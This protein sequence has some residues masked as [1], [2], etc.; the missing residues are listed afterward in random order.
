MKRI[1]TN[2][3]GFDQLVSGGIPEK[4]LVILTGYA[5]TGKTIFALQF[6]LAADEPGLFV[7]FE[8]DVDQIR[9][10]AR[11][12]GWN[13][14]E[15]E[16]NNKVRIVKYDPFRIGDIMEIIES[17]IKEIDAKRVVIDSISALGIHI[18]QRYEIRTVILQLNSILAKNDCTTLMIS[19][20]PDIRKGITRFGVEE[21]I[22]NGVIL[23]DRVLKHGEFHRLITVL[24]MRC[25]GHS[26]KTHYYDINEKGFVVYPD[27]IV[28]TDFL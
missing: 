1:K 5:G 18:G 12:F 28:D 16:K 4:D 3:P 2:I 24:K 19:E 8:E 20:I 21:F 13:I 27:K 22:A 26:R 9:E 11:S 15:L 25:T 6:L 10:I 7:S 23:L 14:D 17:T